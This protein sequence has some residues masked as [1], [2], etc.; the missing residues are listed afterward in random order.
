MLFAKISVVLA[1]LAASVFAA[2]QKRAP[3]QVV[4]KC[5]APNTVA[6]TFVSC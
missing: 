3:A 6:L 5:T 2:P 4:T 1:T